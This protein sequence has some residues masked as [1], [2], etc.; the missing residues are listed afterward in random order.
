MNGLFQRLARQALGAN[1][2]MAPIRP[3]ASVHAMAPLMPAPREYPSPIAAVLGTGGDERP[4]SER[5]ESGASGPAARRDGMTGMPRPVTAGQIRQHAYGPDEPPHATESGAPDPQAGIRRASVPRHLLEE[6]VA[7]QAST[8]IVAPAA[9]SRPSMPP[10]RRNDRHEPT[11]VHVHIGRIE[12]T[13]AIEPGAP[14]KSRAAPPRN[15]LSLS[16]YLA[17]G[18]RR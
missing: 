6:T 17:R 18:S 1:G 11:E 2:A 16:E 8:L 15:T 7:A 4:A 10:T 5:N 12:V 9:S 3:A 14:K 13:A